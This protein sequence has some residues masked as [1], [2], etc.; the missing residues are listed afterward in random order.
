LADIWVDPAIVTWTQILLD[1][2]HRLLGTELIERDRSPSKQS[3]MLFQ[4]PFVVVSHDTQADPQLNYGNQ[5]A[6]DLWELD[7]LEFVNTRSKDTAEPVNQ[8]TRQQVLAQVQSQGF[9]QNYQGVRISSS[10]KR[11]DI[12]QTTIWNLTDATGQ[13][14]GQG[15]TF[16]NWRYLESVSSNG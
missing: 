6:L 3:Q 9:I 13:P 11:F 7:W 5:A 15:A 2:Y 16:R 8:T 1:S 12:L 4:A 10:G 14:C